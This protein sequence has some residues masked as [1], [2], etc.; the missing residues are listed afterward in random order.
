MH[1]DDNPMSYS[2]E[3][4]LDYKYRAKSMYRWLPILTTFI[5]KVL[6]RINAPNTINLFTLTGAQDK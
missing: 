2:T 5:G 4:L 1:G 3:A 6:M